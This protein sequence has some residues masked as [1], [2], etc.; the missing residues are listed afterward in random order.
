MLS[1]ST[2]TVKPD[3]SWHLGFSFPGFSGGRRDS[4]DRNSQTAFSPSLMDQY[5]KNKPGWPNYGPLGNPAGTWSSWLGINYPLICALFTRI[6]ICSAPSGT[7]SVLNEEDLV[8]VHL[9]FCTF[10]CFAADFWSQSL[11]SIVANRCWYY[12]SLSAFIRLVQE[13]LMMTV[14]PPK[15]KRLF[16]TVLWQ[17]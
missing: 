10:P 9:K 14:Y 3:S 15:G 2:Y 7:M 5:N 1:S 13:S 17:S 11:F 6:T 8:P 12:Q 16:R 4:M